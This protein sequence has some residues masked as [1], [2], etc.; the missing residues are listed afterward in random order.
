MYDGRD[1]RLVLSGLASLMVKSSFARYSQVGTRRGYTGSPCGSDSAGSRRNYGCAK[2]SLQMAF[3]AIII[4]RRRRHWRCPIRFTRVTPWSRL[5][6]PAMR[7]D[8]PSSML[9]RMDRFGCDPR[10]SRG[11]FRFRRVECIA[12]A[13]L[14]MSSQSLLALGTI[15]FSTIVCFSW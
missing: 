5:V 12:D 6:W 9:G 8:M 14:V 2:L 1:S 10:L 15:A 13:G 7:L 4:I 3:S 11:W